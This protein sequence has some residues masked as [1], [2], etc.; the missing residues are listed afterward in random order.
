VPSDDRRV[1]RKPVPRLGG[2][3]VFVATALATIIVLA[4]DWL[5]NGELPALPLG[6][7]LQGVFLG[8]SLVFVTG[9]LDDIRGVAPRFKLLVQT[10]A[11]LAVVS[12][13][14]VPKALALAPGLPT[15][16]IGVLG[17][18]L[19]ILWIVGITNA[20]N[21]IDGV[22]GLAST[23]ALIGLATCI[24]ADV[25][26]H[27][28]SVLTLS[29][30]MTGALFA[31]LRFNGAPASVFLGDSGSMTIGFFL[32]VRS[33]VSATGPD[34]TVYFLIPL[35]ALAFP[36]A[37]TFIA[38]ARRWLR[39]HP[40]SRA[41][42]RH[43]HHQILA[44]GLSP[45]RTV[46]LL[47]FVFSGFALVGVSVVFAPP[48]FTLALLVGA[49]V[50]GF[51]SIV[52]GVRYLQYSEFAQFANSVASVIRNAR[53]VVRHKIVI[54]DLARSIERAQSLEEI[55]K[56]LD[57][58]SAISGLI[59]VEVVAG[60]SSFIGPE[61]QMIA[62]ADALPWRLD[63][64]MGLGDEERREYLLRVWCAQ[65]QPWQPYGSAERFALKVG[66][67]IEEWMQKNAHLLPATAEQRSKAADRGTRS[68]GESSRTT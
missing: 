33:V 63:Y 40:F 59:Q 54:E 66:P 19:V 4:I 6:G 58:F 43:I 57:S 8:A 29:L 65:P 7:L 60:R 18:P 32:A 23:F 48:K 12:Y 36:V 31:F 45:T 61:G 55:Q 41:D 42:G 13:G 14:L 28:S 51:A 15:Y 68:S 24:A 16:N 9:L 30:A 64:R 44:L 67:A 5:R 22:D 35:V 27:D 56:S 2:V 26:L 49:A 52:Y 10:T 11:A 17:V 21:L 37:D 46:E 47:G 34:G 1:H 50:L 25:L 20:F 62:P 38:M 39:G 3:A 53:S